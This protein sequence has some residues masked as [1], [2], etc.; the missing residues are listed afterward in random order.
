MCRLLCKIAH[1]VVITG[2]VIGLIVSLPV[3]AQVTTGSISGTVTDATGAIIPGAN[4]TIRNV[5][6]NLTRAVN[7]DAA[8]LYTAADLDVGQY[9]I[10]AQQK[11]FATVKKVGIDLT[12]GAALQE[13][14]SLT[15]GATTEVVEVQAT[16]AQVETASSEVGGLVGEKQMVDLPL[17]G[18]NY[19]QLILLA[20]GMQPVTNMFDHQYDR[21]LGNVRRGW[22]ASGSAGDPAGRDRYTRLLY[23]RLR[24]DNVG[25]LL[26]GGGD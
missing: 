11:G 5:G 14:L 17:N 22:V 13:N 23:A 2:V 21:A 25:N 10:T 24:L 12:V 1:Y 16:A 4:V 7:T 26:R 15:V 19:A 20:P 6:T 3:A 18:R 9:E 8:G